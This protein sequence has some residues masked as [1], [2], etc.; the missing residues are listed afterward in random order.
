MRAAGVRAH[1]GALDPSGASLAVDPACVRLSALT[2]L[3]GRTECRVFNASP[4]PV[5]AH[6]SFAPPLTIEAVTKIDL[7]GEPVDELRF[8]GRAVLLTLRPWEIATIRLA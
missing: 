8:D 2:T 3:D 7:L 1:P 4:D 5:E 6:V